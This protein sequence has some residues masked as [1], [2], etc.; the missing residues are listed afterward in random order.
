MRHEPEI[1][2][3]YLSWFLDP[4]TL[5]EFVKRSALILRR[6][7]F[8]C[9]AFRGVSGALS[10]PPLAFKMNKTVIVVRKSK[11]EEKNHSR[12]LV[13]GDRAVKRYVIVDDFISS[14]A[15]AREIVKRISEFAPSARCI[16][17]IEGHRIIKNKVLAVTD[18]LDRLPHGWAGR[19]QYV[20]HANDALKRTQ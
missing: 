19:E 15:T 1:I 7:D 17:V 5:K 9:I 11:Y 6:Y 12:M 10:G 4:E 8:Q 13:E 2:S 16:G 3:R 18:I 20:M 14:G